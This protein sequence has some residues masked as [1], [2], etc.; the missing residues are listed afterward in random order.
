MSNHHDYCYY[1]RG[2]IAAHKNSRQPA[3]QPPSANQIYESS[4]RQTS[5]AGNW[6]RPA[7]RPP[8]GQGRAS[9]RQVEPARVH[10]NRCNCDSRPPLPL[11]HERALIQKVKIIIIIR[12]SFLTF[13]QTLSHSKYQ[14][15]SAAGFERAGGGG[16]GGP[17]TS[18]TSPPLASS[19]S[20]STKTYLSAGLVPVFHRRSL[21]Y[22]ACAC[23]LA[24]CSLCAH[25]AAGPPNLAQLVLEIACLALALLARV[26][27]GQFPPRQL[28]PAVGES[29]LL[30][31]ELAFDDAVQ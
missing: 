8:N 1:D 25:S 19:G 17:P 28:R 26:R 24:C 3:S 6:R 31:F 11:S 2:V 22:E 7:A 27:R 12:C 15:S 30:L 16:G 14:S 4:A 29:L 9:R 10:C 20:A 21:A 18:E 5:R 23:A 13:A